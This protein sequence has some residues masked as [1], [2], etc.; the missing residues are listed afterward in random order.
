MMLHSHIPDDLT[1][2]RVY[3]QWGQ[4]GTGQQAALRLKVLINSGR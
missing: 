1:V 3:L 4:T 2:T